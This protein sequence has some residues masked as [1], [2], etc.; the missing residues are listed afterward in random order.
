MMTKMPEESAWGVFAGWFFEGALS[1]AALAAGLAIGIFTGG[2]GWAILG[3][4]DA[5]A[6]QYVGIGTLST[7]LG[8]PGRYIHSPATMIDLED[9]EAVKEIAKKIIETF[10]DE[11]LKD[12]LN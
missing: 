10:D 8:V 2:A 12:L 5:G 1:A 9:L 4:T 6:A 3:G 7:T 11:K